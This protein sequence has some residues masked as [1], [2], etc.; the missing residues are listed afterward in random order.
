MEEKP[1]TPYQSARVPREPPAVLRGKGIEPE[2]RLVPVASL[3]V[4]LPN[5]GLYGN[6]PNQPAVWGGGTTN[7]LS[8]RFHFSCDGEWKNGPINFGPIRML[9]DCMMM[10]QRVMEKKEA[11]LELLT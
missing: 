11:D 5:P 10:P 8:R 2:L 9:N 3:W 4:S 1:P 6:P 7:W